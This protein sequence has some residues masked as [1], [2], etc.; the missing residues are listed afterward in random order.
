MRSRLHLLAAFALAI[1]LPAAPAFAQDFP[2]KPVKIIVP[3]PPGGTPDMLSRLLSQR[4]TQLLG[5]QVVVDNR[6]GAGG[7]VAMELVARAPADGY[8]LIMGSIGTC[9]INPYI[10]RTIGFDV[11]RDFAPL[12]EVG[13]IAN[14]LAVHPSV[15]A[16]DVKEL[17]ALIR[18][19]PGEMTYASS[20]FGSSLHL[21]SELFE[22]L[23]GI[24]IRHV[25]YKGSALAVT[26]LVG[27]EV[28]FMFDNMP[29]IAPHAAGGRVRPI[30][31]TGTR[32]S[33]LFPDVPTMQEAGY[34]DVV[35]QPWFG[36]LAPAKTPPAVLAK[37]NAVFNEAM[38]D[39]TVQKRLTEIDVESVGGSGAD[40][41]KHIRAESEKW[42]RLIRERK[43]T[44]E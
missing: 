36:L 28:N 5:Q 25:P 41:G 17:V 24:Q 2:R 31:V 15:P 19:K 27:G 23:A 14:L 40:F 22:S 33:K 8:T 16:K 35:M 37:L 43:I 13:R 39:P 12:M 21:T 26:A 6:P 38:R 4:A 44:A 42:S 29:S 34:K 30:A 32:R 11:E 7:N 1:A 20:G 18:A 9:S 10:Y 3:F